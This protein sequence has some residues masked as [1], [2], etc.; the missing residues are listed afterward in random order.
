MV[1][2]VTRLCRTLGRTVTVQITSIRAR[3]TRKK[4]MGVW[5]LGLL[6]MV[7][8]IRPLPTMATMNKIKKKQKRVSW[9]QESSTKLCRMIMVT[10]DWF[11]GAMDNTVYA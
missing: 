3:L 10:T 7:V 1:F 6:W 2:S 5:R 11:S 4:Y 9:I 8:I